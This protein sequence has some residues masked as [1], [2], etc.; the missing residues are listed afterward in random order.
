MVF[1]QNLLIL[2]LLLLQNGTDK[3]SPLMSVWNQLWVRFVVFL[4]NNNNNTFE[5][6][7]NLDCLSY[8]KVWFQQRKLLLFFTEKPCK[9]GGAVGWDPEVKS[10]CLQVNCKLFSSGK[11]EYLAYLSYRELVPCI[12]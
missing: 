9:Y 7:K 12:K 10:Q 11:T 5:L 2:L 3:E 4:N 6:L 8:V 1:N